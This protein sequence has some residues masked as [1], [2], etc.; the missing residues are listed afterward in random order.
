MAPLEPLSRREVGVGLLPVRLC[1]G[2]PEG[3]HGLLLGERVTQD[4]GSIQDFFTLDAVGFFNPGRRRPGLAEF[5][6]FEFQGVGVSRIEAP[7]RVDRIHLNQ[8][9]FIGT[10][11]NNAT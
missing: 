2:V 1:Q 7:L 4:M 6:D 11:C 10:S 8:R 5:W 9:V 3:P